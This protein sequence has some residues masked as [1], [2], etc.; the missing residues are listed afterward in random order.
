[1][2]RNVV[3]EDIMEP[4]REL[5]WKYKDG[6]VSI[7]TPLCGVIVVIGDFMLAVEWLYHL[8][9]TDSVEVV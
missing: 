8:S 7:K 9:H 5:S 3:V 1:M 4:T 6:R 2:V